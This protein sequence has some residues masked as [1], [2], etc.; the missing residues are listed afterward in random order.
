MGIVKT[1]VIEEL[2][3]G[4]QLQL[5]E[6]EISGGQCGDCGRGRGAE[7]AAAKDESMG[8]GIRPAEQDLKS[9]MQLAQGRI[10]AYQNASPKVRAGAAQ[11]DMELI[12]AKGLI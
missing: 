5:G 2:L 12:C 11:N 10:A 9:L 4:L 1:V 6:T 3:L 8:M 7:I